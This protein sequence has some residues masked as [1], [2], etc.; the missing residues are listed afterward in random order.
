MADNSAIFKHTVFRGGGGMS[1]FVEDFVILMAYLKNY[2]YCRLPNFF[3]ILKE[4]NSVVY[5]FLSTVVT[6]FFVVP[7]FK[8]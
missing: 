6:L 1:L 2:T 7:R 5:F 4:N 8:S 3:V